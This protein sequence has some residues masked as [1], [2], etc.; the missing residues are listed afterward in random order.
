[1]L[2]A[3]CA[4]LAVGGA[5]RSPAAQGQL[6]LRILDQQTGKP[7]ACRMHL[8]TAA[9]RARLPKQAA[10]W[11]DHFVVPGRILLRLPLGSYTFQIERGP[12]YPVLSGHFTINKF[13]DDSKQI[14]LRRHVDMSSQGWWSGDLD[15][16]RPVGDIELLMAAEDLHV[17]PLVTWWNA[18]SQR[19]AETPRRDPLLR[20]DQD[21]FCHALGGQQAWPGGTLSFF[22]LPA[23]IR[24]GSP[25]AEYPS[26]IQLL[27]RLRGQPAAWVDATRPYWQDLPM[28]VALGQVDSIQ[29]AHGDMCRTRMLPPPAN[30]GPRD[31]KRYAH[32]QGMGRWSHDI[33]FHL[34]ECG[35]RIPPSAGSGSGAGPNP[36]G[37]NRVYVHVA[38]PLSYEK[39]WQG[40]RAGRVT[41]TNGPLLEP[42]VH[43]QLPGHVFHG[44]A[45]QALEFQIALTL[46]TR[47]PISYLEII[48]NGRV[49][50]EVRFDDYR[51]AGRLPKLRFDQSG[52]FLVRAVTD[53]PN[54]FRFGMT[55]PYYVEIG[56]RPRIS[57][58]SVQCMLDWVEQRAAQIQIEQP[59]RRAEVL[60][61]HQRARQFWLERLSRANTE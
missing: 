60:Q 23:P 61:A 43:G 8:K 20:F 30:A 13:A 36:P 10:A 15:V 45:G 11:D 27:R 12:E 4:V 19:S 1:M 58:R 59:D 34:L 40:L 39:W 22:N 25:N 55:G 3:A 42:S 44:P 6:E 32:V 54:T 24:L 46:H 16:R 14:Q 26:P 2:A 5:A 52:W 38:G 7:T 47:E 37:Y 53:L 18:P 56:S 35:L 41:V 21:R 50:H 49:E 33:Y 48:K 31:P 57:K 28:L 29:V 51:Q 9:G 17:V